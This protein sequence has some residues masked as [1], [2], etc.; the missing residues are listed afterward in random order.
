VDDDAG[1]ADRRRRLAG[2]LEDLP[3]PVADV[4]LRRADVDQVRRVDVDG[5]RGVADRIGLGVGRGLLVGPRV[6]K[7]DL[8]A[9]G[10][11]LCRGSEQ[12]RPPDVGADRG[13]GGDLPSIRGV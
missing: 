3:R 2:L 10:V 8:E 6:G 12:L 5:E 11:E 13:L 4:R 9:V 7:E 1:G